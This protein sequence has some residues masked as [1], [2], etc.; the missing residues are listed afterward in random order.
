[1]RG[2]QPSSSAC[3]LGSSRSVEHRGSAA[4][5]QNRPS[6]QRRFVSCIRLFAGKLTPSQVLWL[7]ARALGNAS[8]HL[9]TQ[10]LVIVKSKGDVWPP[11]SR[12][13]AV[14]TDWRL[15]AQPILRSAARMREARVLGQAVTRR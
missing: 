14:G 3:S 15:M 9:R 7:E 6:S 2:R 5:L 13:R 11:L 12:K 10:L 8:E 4:K 1:M